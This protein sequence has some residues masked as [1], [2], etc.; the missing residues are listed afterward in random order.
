MS[1]FSALSS[2]L[3]L[4]EMPGHPVLLIGHHPR[5]EHRRIAI[6]ARA[7]YTPAA[8]RRLRLLDVH[9]GLLGGVTD[10]FVLRHARASQSVMVAKAWAYIGRSAPSAR[11]PSLLCRETSQ[12]KPRLM[13]LLVGPFRFMRLAGARNGSKAMGV[14]ALSARRKLEPEQV[15]PRH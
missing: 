6:F 10:A 8:A 14:A 1:H 11:L 13:C 3:V 9:H 7:L 2:M 15:P 4:T 12:A 5:T